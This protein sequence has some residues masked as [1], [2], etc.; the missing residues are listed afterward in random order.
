MYLNA[1]ILERYSQDLPRYLSDPARF[2]KI[3][4]ISCK[5]CKD[6]REILQ[7]LPRYSRD[8]ARFA[9]IL[10]RHNQD[11]PR[12]SRDLARFAK[13]LER[14]SQDLPRSLGD[15]AKII[16]SIFQDV[17]VNLVSTFKKLTRTL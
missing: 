11:L 17:F 7:G 8:F 1:M 10:E 5:V 16:A 12:Y 2:A 14:Y 6:T 13:L 9:M 3:L 15:I 4:E